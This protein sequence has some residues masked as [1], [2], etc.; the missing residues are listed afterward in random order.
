M[1]LKEVIPLKPSWAKDYNKKVDAHE[2]FNE[3][4]H[5]FRYDIL[6]RC[7]PKFIIFLESLLLHY[8]CKCKLN[9][10]SGDR[11]VYHCDE[12]IDGVYGGIDEIFESYKCTDDGLY[13]IPNPTKKQL[14]RGEHGWPLC[15]SQ[16]GRKY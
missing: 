4:K 2:T 6:S 5:L 15:K 8:Y 3:Q 12:E 9:F 14:A 16:E 1:T 10:S 7:Q 13:D 11:L